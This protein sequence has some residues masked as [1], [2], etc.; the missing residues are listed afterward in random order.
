MADESKG[1]F[2]KVYFFRVEHFAQVR[3]SLPD[4]LRRIR[5]LDFDDAGRYKYDA[6]T[7]LRLSAYPDTD[8]YPLRI[9]FGRIRRE[10]LPDVEH[11]GALQTLQLQEDAGLIDMSHV[12]VFDDGYVAAEWNPDGPKLAS[13]GAYIFEKGRLNTSPKF[14]SILERDIV[15]VLNKLSSVKILEIDLPPN[16]VELAREADENLAA[17]VQATAALGATKRTSLTL[18][19]DKPTIKLRDLAIRLANLVRSRP[20]ES[21]LLNNLS[22]KGY[23]PESRVARYIDILESKLI[24]GDYFPRT[25]ERS[26]SVN[27]DE[28]YKILERLYGENADRIKV[29]ATTYDLP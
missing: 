6:S 21:I 12:V 9:R 25:S 22:V 7:R 11:A 17:A 2:R 18:T 4:A 26:R 19:S 1:I 20:Q 28:T 29:A 13:L 24:S 15:E 3:E 14:L 5:G 10:A 23:Y 16:A 27:S 8:T